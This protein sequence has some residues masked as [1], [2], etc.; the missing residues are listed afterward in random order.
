M[1]MQDILLSDRNADQE[2]LAGQIVDSALKVHS[3]LAPGMLESAYEQC[4]SCELEGCG[5]DVTRQVS[6]PIRYRDIQIDAAYRMDLLV[7]GIIAVEIKSV[8]ALLPIHE[9]QILTYLKFSGLR[10][11]F[12]LNFNVTLIKHGI[13]RFVR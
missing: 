7:G 8:E 9:A 10:L 2:L 12:L 13:R 1:I 11:G 4:L 6:V 3:A 5:I